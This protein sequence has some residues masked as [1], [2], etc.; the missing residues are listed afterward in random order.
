MVS[1]L[2]TAQDLKDLVKKY[3]DDPGRKPTGSDRHALQ[4]TRQFDGAGLGK[5]AAKILER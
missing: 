2:A 1:K 3:E 4:R 5:R